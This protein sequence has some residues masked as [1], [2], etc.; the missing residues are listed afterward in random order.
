[1]LRRHP[2]MALL[3]NKVMD[4][5]GESICIDEPDAQTHLP[6]VPHDQLARL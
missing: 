6:D 1:M 4:S 5:L 2:Q 3:H